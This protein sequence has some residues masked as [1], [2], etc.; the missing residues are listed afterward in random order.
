MCSQGPHPTWHI[1]LNNHNMTFDTILGC[2]HALTIAMSLAKLRSDSLFSFSRQN[3]ESLKLNATHQE[4]P[5]LR[6]SCTTRLQLGHQ[7]TMKKSV[8][9]QYMQYCNALQIHFTLKLCQNTQIMIEET[10]MK[11]SV[12]S[13]VM[14]VLLFSS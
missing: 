12:L 1:T 9:I 3:K 14:F 8:F 7:I 2:S 5:S 10:V 4:Q 13:I 6:H 11:I